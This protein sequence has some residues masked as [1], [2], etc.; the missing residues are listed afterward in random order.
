MGKVIEVHPIA[1][2][3]VYTNPVWQWDYGCFLH[4]NDIDLPFSY[5]AEFSNTSARGTA[6]SYTQ[7]TDMV[8]IPKS[9]QE[10]GEPIYIWIVLIDEE[11][12]ITEYMINVAVKPRSSRALATASYQ[13]RII[14]HYIELSAAS[15]FS[16]LPFYCL[17]PA[18]M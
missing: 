12:R 1:G 9:Y 7:T 17:V 14:R 6:K 8:E 11:S 10:S 18:A 13:P 5:Q 2:K 15:S 4:L 16:F 3:I